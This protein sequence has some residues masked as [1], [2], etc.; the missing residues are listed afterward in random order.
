ML[1]PRDLSVRAGDQLTGMISFFNTALLPVECFPERLPTGRW[2]M[3]FF[4]RYDGL[5]P[6]ILVRANTAALDCRFT[7][8]LR[9]GAASSS[10]STFRVTT[11]GSSTGPRLADEVLRLELVAELVELGRID[12][13]FEPTRM[14]LD[15]EA[16]PR[17]SPGLLR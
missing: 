14:G 7:G 15:D 4:L 9:P 16:A 12:A 8:A 6:E 11:G 1:L 5:P 10:G 3:Q 13:R 2:L 17:R